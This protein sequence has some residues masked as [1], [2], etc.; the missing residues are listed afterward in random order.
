MEDD[1]AK[2]DEGADKSQAEDDTANDNDGDNEPG[3]IPLPPGQQ[4]NRWD[5]QPSNVLPKARSLGRSSLRTSSVLSNIGKASS[6]KS[7]PQDDAPVDK[8]SEEEMESTKKLKRTKQ[9]TQSRLKQVNSFIEKRLPNILVVVGEGL[10]DL[11]KFHDECVAGA[12]DTDFGKFYVKSVQES[13]FRTYDLFDIIDYNRK[14][15][16]HACPSHVI[17]WDTDFNTREWRSKLGQ[18]EPLVKFAV[19]KE[20]TEPPQQVPCQSLQPHPWNS[21]DEA[22]NG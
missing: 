20:L 15:N 7:K 21:I 9:S 12:M 4:R 11:P 22:P 3:S 16:I 13:P 8:E 18:R 19:T 14:S 5:K 17:D 2:E 1:T 6:K 10:L